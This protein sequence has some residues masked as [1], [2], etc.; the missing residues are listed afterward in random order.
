MFAG[1]IMMI[2]DFNPRSPRGLRLHR[3]S[4]I[5]KLTNISIHA[6]Q[7]GCDPALSQHVNIAQNFN[8]RSPRGLRPCIFF[9]IFRPFSI[10]IHAAQEGCDWCC[11]A[12]AYAFDYFN[13]RSPRGLRPLPLMKKYHF[14]IFQSTQPKRA[15]TSATGHTFFIK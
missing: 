15:A 10:S 5:E 14:K 13:P 7:E 12:I 9:R 8:P 2:H 6:A 11:N 3:A 4:D 1:S